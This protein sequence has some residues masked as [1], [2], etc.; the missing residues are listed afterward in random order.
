[1]HDAQSEMMSLQE[2][3]AQIKE[4]QPLDEGLLNHRDFTGLIFSEALHQ[5]QDASVFTTRADTEEQDDDQT[6]GSAVSLRMAAARNED[7]AITFIVQDDLDLNINDRREDGASAVWIAAE[8][9]HAECISA[10][11]DIGGAHANLPNTAGVTPLYVAMYKRMLAQRDSD[12]AKVGQY[13]KAIEALLDGDSN[14]KECQADPNY[15]DKNGKSLLHMACQ[16]G[17]A[18]VVAQLIVKGA[19]P[20]CLDQ[21]SCSPL[22]TVLYHGY[23]IV[24]EEVEV[25]AYKDTLGALLSSPGNQKDEHIAHL[26]NKQDAMGYTDF[27][28]ACENNHVEVAKQLLKLG[29]KV[30]TI[31]NQG[32]TPLD[33]IIASSFKDGSF[34]ASNFGE[35]TTLLLQQE[36][37]D[38]QKS[39]ENGWTL[40]HTFCKLGHVDAVNLLLERGADPSGWT[41]D[42]LTP[43]YITAFYR[44]KQQGKQT[45]PFDAII[46]SLQRKDSLVNQAN[47]MG[48]TLLHLAVE[49]K[50]ASV[51]K[52]LLAHDADVDACDTRGWS[53]L[54]VAAHHNHGA[55]VM[56]LLE[57]GANF[58]LR[59]NAGE[60]ALEMAAK[61]G[62]QQVVAALLVNHRD[63]VD[64]LSLEHQQTPLIL[65]AQV[66]H[67]EV[68][69]LFLELGANIEHV[70][71]QGASALWL[72]AQGGQQAVVDT[73]LAHGASVLVPNQQG[74]TFL[75]KAVT[76]QQG[77]KKVLPTLLGSKHLDPSII[78][79]VDKNGDAPLHTLVKTSEPDAKSLAL[80]KLLVAHNAN[81]DQLDG[82]HQYLVYHVLQQ[83][84]PTWLERLLTLKANPNAR[85]TDGNTPLHNHVH[86]HYDEQMLKLLVQYKADF[87]AWKQPA[88]GAG[89]DEDTNGLTPL[90]LAVMHQDQEVVEA[91]LKLKASINHPSQE[92]DYSALSIATQ[93][94]LGTLVEVLVHA[95][96]DANFVG[97]D[98]YAPLH[99]VLAREVDEDEDPSDRV[100]MV[101]RL[102]QAKGININLSV[103]LDQ[104]TPLHVAAQN[105]HADLAQLLVAHKAALDVYDSNGWTPIGNAAYFGAMPV[106]EVLLDAGASVQMQDKG[107]HDVLFLAAQAGR[108]Q[109]VQ[110]L[111]DHLEHTTLDVHRALFIAAQHGHPSTVAV[112]VRQ[113]VD[114]LASPKSKSSAWQITVRKLADMQQHRRAGL[115]GGQLQ[116][117]LKSFDGASSLAAIIGRF[118]QI[119]ALMLGWPRWY[120]AD[121]LQVDEATEVRHR[122]FFQVKCAKEGTELEAQ[123]PLPARTRK[124]EMDQLS[125]HAH[126]AALHAVMTMQIWGVLG[127]GGVYARQY[128]LTSMVPIKPINKRSID[129]VMTH[130]VR[131]PIAH[132]QPFGTSLMQCLKAPGS[133]KAPKH[134]LAWLRESDVPGVV[135]LNKEE[136]G[137]TYRQELRLKGVV[138]TMVLG[139]IMD[140]TGIFDADTTGVVFEA[141]GDGNLVQGRLVQLDPGK[142]LLF[143]AQGTDPASGGPEAA[144][145]R[146]IPCDG[147]RFSIKWQQMPD[148]LKKRFSATLWRMMDLLH[149]NHAK[150]FQA[151]TT[152]LQAKLSRV[153]R[154]AQQKIA[155]KLLGAWKLHLEALSQLY[156]KMEGQIQA[157]SA[158]ECFHA[159]RVG[160]IRTSAEQLLLAEEQERV[161][162]LTTESKSE[163][164]ARER[165]SYSESKSNR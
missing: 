54:H 127:H 95:N 126:Q 64:M 147:G 156:P 59:T 27:H 70:N 53:A 107:Q 110:W 41:K 30:N 36:E 138:E 105:G 79:A 74:Q 135:C 56:M 28:K 119:K 35:I 162:Q 40:L 67:A 14:N 159:A 111:L 19:N 75:H 78:D 139:R 17:H 128:D 91:L 76:E 120:E 44:A 88:K 2:V 132:L 20:T 102:L 45:D 155:E 83:N 149:D 161:L 68:V 8:Y 29:A 5:K 22:Y 103:G 7:A 130:V 113:G 100:A 140:N 48:Q 24:D 131:H 34:D 77:N 13:D 23:E 11:L 25:S 15:Q 114:P 12:S 47:E 84:N 32:Q 9:G 52:W 82:E 92:N 165:A 4:I 117:V 122:A 39:D 151:L 124:L 69:A 145:P 152:G 3:L 144:D 33:S 16:Q 115:T 158:D 163:Q 87:N 123:L 57:G 99:F 50:H 108:A 89:E 46:K 21:E 96:A 141:N 118:E 65:A 26:V 85:N 81:V 1:M 49:K 153:S 90:Q 80:A 104:E 43:L 164:A 160:A 72:A 51:V 42:G 62:Y 94:G 109:M 137:I 31:N 98:G 61:S 97:S 121:L 142:S 129:Q 143:S 106:A 133:T 112:M 18:G 10:L 55:M 136:D 37:I 125:L 38:V 66:G 134:L 60:T 93:C 63:K 58:D 6:K 71:D 146:D 73:L 154:A 116:N 150:F 157:P 148:A 86:K 101:K